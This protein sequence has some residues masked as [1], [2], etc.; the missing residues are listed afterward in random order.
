[1]A[2]PA[3]P[4]VLFVTGRL[5]EAALREVLVDLAPR[6][7]IAAEVAVLPIS[8]AALMTPKWIA[9]HLEVPEGVA[10][11]VLPGNCRGDLSAVEARAGVPV[12]LGPEDLR[13]LPRSLGQASDRLAGYG[14]YDIEILAEIN[15]APR[16]ALDDFLARAEAFVAEGADRIDVGCDPGGPWLGVGDHVRALVDRGIKASVDSFDPVEVA[17]A[18]RGGA[19]LVLSV[20]ASNREHAPDWGVEVVAIPDVVGTLDGLDATAEFLERRGVRFRLDPILEPIGFGFAASLARYAEARRRW[21]SAEILMGIGNLTELL[22][23]DSAG[24]NALLVGFCQEL[25]VRS[26]LTT[27]VINWARTSVREV[28]LARR[29]AYHAV[30]RK[31]LPK[32]VDPGLILLRDDRIPRFG[33]EALR[34]MASKVKDPNWRIYAEDGRIIAFNRDHFL[35]GSDPYDVFGR[36][37]ID[38]PS[39]AFYLGLELMKAKTALTLGKAYRQ[40]QALDWGYLTEPEVSHRPTRIKPEAG[41]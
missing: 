28:D 41:S 26:V 5:A 36:M 24:V 22:D 33:P 15:H 8:V 13:D 31:A 40:D 3:L 39:H 9:R 17:E 2:D 16:L 12:S 18:V 14:A 37:G 30:T 27:A 4:L 7:G 25:G 32:R 35:E 19:D 11:V 20:N 10:R 34:V 29:L 23:V 38:D 21:P 1:M 6:A